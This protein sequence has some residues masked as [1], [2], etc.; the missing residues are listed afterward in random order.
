M[1]TIKFYIN[2]NSSSFVYRILPEYIQQKYEE[3]IDSDEQDS[4]SEIISDSSES[5]F[6]KN[7]SCKRGLYLFDCYNRI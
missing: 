7:I 2:Y 4:D 5:A 3:D 6:G 1:T